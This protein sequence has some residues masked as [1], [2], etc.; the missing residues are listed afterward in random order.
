MHEGLNAIVALGLALLAIAAGS[1]C[2]RV[3]ENSD[4]EG[5]VSRAIFFRTQAAALLYVPSL[6][7][8]AP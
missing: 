5:V 1:P 2:G 4:P 6:K 3:T 8:G 7:A